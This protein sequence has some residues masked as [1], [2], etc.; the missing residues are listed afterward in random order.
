M[1]LALAVMEMERVSFKE[2][3]EASTHK[4]KPCVHPLP[5][6]IMAMISFITS[7]VPA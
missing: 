2:V 3:C 7:L 5:E 4:L 1:K 6:I